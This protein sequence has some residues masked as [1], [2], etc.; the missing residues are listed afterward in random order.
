MAKA[1]DF[2]SSL[3]GI[4]SRFS[5]NNFHLYQKCMRLSKSM[6]G[7]SETTLV[8]N[9]VGKIAMKWSVSLVN[10]NIRN[11]TLKEI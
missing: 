7:Q 9:F 4:K 3:L 8:K 10:A 1:F 5:Q 2:K 11:R 6:G